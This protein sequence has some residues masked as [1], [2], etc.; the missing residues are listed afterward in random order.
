MTLHIFNPSHEE[1][2]AANSPFYCPSVMARRLS[3][4]WGILPILWAKDNDCILLIN[5]E[6]YRICEWARK[7]RKNIRLIVP[8][9]LSPVLWQEVERI[10]PWGWDLRICHLLRKWDVPERLLP[11][12]ETLSTIRQ[13]S[14]RVTTS[15]MLPL[16][17]KCMEK[18]N[19][20]TIGESVIA[21]KEEDVK[22][23]LRKWKNVMVKSLWSCSGRGVFGLRNKATQSEKGRILRLLHQQGGVEIEPRYEIA[24]NFALEF[25]I[26]KNETPTFQ[27]LSLFTSSLSGNYTG[28]W[29]TDQSVIVE[30][31]TKKGF[32]REKINC[33]TD[34]V[35]KILQNFISNKYEGYLGID[36]MLVKTPCKV[37]LHPCVEINLR[38]TMGHIALIMHEEGVD[39]NSLPQ[40]LQRPWIS[41]Q[42]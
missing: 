13:L 37:L 31:L 27:G 7:W 28:N 17:R 23:L 33:I 41:I 8:K 42:P 34:C 36:M 39:I 38:R 32:Q 14:S 40:S 16:L 21:T 4:E 22:L 10:E 19:I 12:D 35:V 24:A 9:D 25:Y 29:I 6:A 5:A 3:I 15:A 2:M 18:E 1:A 30:E 20:E 26:G 11:N